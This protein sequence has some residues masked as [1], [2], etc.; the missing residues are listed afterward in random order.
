[1]I[2]LDFIKKL[3]N[4]PKDYNYIVNIVIP[5][6][7]W[8]LSKIGE[9]TAK[10]CS[11]PGVTMKTSHEAD[12]KAD[13]N[14]YCDIQNTY[15]GQK[16]NL[17]IGM[18]T[19]ADRNSQE[20]LNNMFRQKK[21]LKNLDGIVLM[22]ER[23]RKMVEHTGFPKDR[24][25]TI[26]PGQ[27]YDLFPLKKINIGIVSR[28]GYPGK[29]QGFMEKLFSKHKLAG[30]RFRFLGS[31]WDALLPIAKK[32]N[33]EIELLPDT[34][35]SVYP[36]FYQEIDYLLIPG[37]WEAG[38][39]S[40]QEALSTGVPI[41]TADVGFTG[42]E[43]QTEFIFPP[44]DSKGLY[45]ILQ[46]IRKPL[47]KRRQQTEHMTWEK[48]VNDL[49][50]YFHHIE[51]LNTQKEKRTFTYY[52]IIGKDLN[53]LKGHV[54]N[55]K[56]YAGFDKIPGKKEFLIIV[57]RN[58]NIS[59]STTKAILDFCKSQNIRTHI[60]DEPNNVFIKNLYACWNLG[61]EL[62]Q[63][64]YVLRG[65]SDQVFSRNS[66]LSL[67]NESEK[68]RG[69]GITNVV[70]QANTIENKKRLKEIGAKSRHFSEEFGDNFENFDYKKFESFEKKINKGIKKQ[71]I[72]INDALRYWKKPTSELTSLGRINRV[73][74]CSW[75]MTKKDWQKYGPLPVVEN[76][77]TGD[78][79]IHDRLQ[80]AGYTEYIVKDCITY[81]FV[82]GESMS[83][84]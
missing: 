21:V 20:W 11:I 66:F 5:K 10:A 80:Q 60:Y 38:P 64:G 22:N 49:V 17:D 75:L 61:Y 40:T 70:L 72:D 19:H 56:E 18:M 12:P 31:G 68:L 23:Y 34:D 83:K 76:G 35:Y 8:I 1:M 4:K 25:T 51:T 71:L 79:I 13:V 43:F 7:G 78:V 69:K 82:R 47:Q 84:Y 28:G 33:I 24:I 46:T 39:M 9:R 2:N 52:T 42:F 14:Y 45:E 15:F 36:K 59:P 6:S 32:K 16:T 62:S 30:F 63:D 65:G 54:K 41:I 44:G 29:G 77:I 74:G 58:R 73:D 37:L 57:Y 50:N 48:Y 3:N 67:Y 55:V 26:V 27:T 81:H 53:L